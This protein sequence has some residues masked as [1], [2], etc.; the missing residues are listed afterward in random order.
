MLRTCNCF[1]ELEENVATEYSS[2]ENA[3]ECQKME[4]VLILKS[5]TCRTII[6]MPTIPIYIILNIVFSILSLC[7][8]E[9]FE[10]KISIIFDFLG[11]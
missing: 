4:C 9:C 7:T 3:E 10:W 6:R 11:M 8:G 2:M 5:Q 1:A